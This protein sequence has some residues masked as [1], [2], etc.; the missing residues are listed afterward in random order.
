M[1][2]E[3][4]QIDYIAIESRKCKK[5]K[6]KGQRKHRIEPVTMHI[7]AYRAIETF[8]LSPPDSLAPLSPTDVWRPFGSFSIVSRR[9]HLSSAVDMSA[10]VALMLPYLN[11]EVWGRGDE[12]GNGENGGRE[13]KVGKCGEEWKE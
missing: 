2:R 4:R 1:E 9:L 6:K 10:D 8:C 13:V 11:G 12:G 5:D 7:R 3:R